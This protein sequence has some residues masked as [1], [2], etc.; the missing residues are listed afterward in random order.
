MCSLSLLSSL[1]CSRHQCAGS[2]LVKELPENANTHELVD[3]VVQRRDL[4][5]PQVIPELRVEVG[6][7][8]DKK[9]TEEHDPDKDTK[10]SSKVK[11]RHTNIFSPVF[12]SDLPPRFK[13]Q[14]SHF[15]D[16]PEGAT[17]EEP[18]ANPT[19]NSQ[20]PVLPKMQQDHI[21]VATE[22]HYSRAPKT[23]L[24]K[25]KSPKLLSLNP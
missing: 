17:G 15:D 16:T 9:K 24:P 22:T 3:D 12:A 19:L 25:S 13:R 2:S 4:C 20:F 6:P 14:I 10:N 8:L 1:V 5:V 18:T 23:D 11:Q 7:P 21:H